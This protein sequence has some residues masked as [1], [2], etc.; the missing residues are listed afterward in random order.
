MPGDH[1]HEGYLPPLPL[2]RHH[3]SD[4]DDNDDAGGRGVCCC[5]SNLPESDHCLALGVTHGLLFSILD[6][7]DSG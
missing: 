6:Q 5:L 2:C 4:D 1:Q 7:C 3:R